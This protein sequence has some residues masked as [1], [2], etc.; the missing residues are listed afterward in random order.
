MYVNMN[1]CEGLRYLYQDMKYDYAR[2]YSY[3]F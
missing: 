2:D 1:V 3:V